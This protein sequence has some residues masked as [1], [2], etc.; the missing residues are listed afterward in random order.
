MLIANKWE[1]E[2]GNIYT[3]VT[4]AGEYIGRLEFVDRSVV[5]ILTPL[6]LMADPNGSQQFIPTI[7]MTGINDPKFVDFNA[8]AVI[9]ITETHEAYQKEYV[10]ATSGLIIR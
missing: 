3:V 5:R 9:S 4:V 2:K 10:K 1:V 7:S 8:T 6:L